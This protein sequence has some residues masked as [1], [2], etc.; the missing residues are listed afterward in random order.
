MV[1]SFSSSIALKIARLITAM[2][3]QTGQRVKIWKAVLILEQYKQV[4]VGDRSVEDAWR[5]S[6]A[7]L[8]C[9]AA[10]RRGEGQYWRDPSRLYTQHTDEHTE[11]SQMETRRNK[12]TDLRR[13]KGWYMEARLDMRGTNLK[14][15][16]E[17]ED[18]GKSLNT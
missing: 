15:K 18:M 4:N 11:T 6:A 2:L 12:H 5:L 16:N 17:I 13:D 14:F 10:V 1:H 8:A 7:R 9:Y 3:T